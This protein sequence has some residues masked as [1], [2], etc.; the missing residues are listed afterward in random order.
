MGT[1]AL[2]IRY[3]QSTSS[4]VPSTDMQNAATDLDGLITADRVRLSALET[5]PA[6]T[7]YT[8]VWSS[9]GTQPTLG[10]GSLTGAYNQQGS[11][12]TVRIHL[13]LGSTSTVGTGA[14]RFTL[15]AGGQLNSLLTALFKDTSLSTRAS[16][17]VELVSTG[18]TG[19]NM[20]INV[21]GNTGVVGATIPVVPANG[22]EII[23]CGTYEAA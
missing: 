23:I 15:P 21:D 16:G 17:S 14:Y 6:W 3:P 12:I 22:D 7:S 8:P 9:S 13:T 1:T 5:R 20:R 2:G 18:A 10:N 11:M 19:D 4:Y